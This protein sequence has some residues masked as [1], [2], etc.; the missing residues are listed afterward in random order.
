MCREEGVHQRSC[1]EDNPRREGGSSRGNEGE[2]EEPG[3][4]GNLQE[5]PLYG[6]AGSGRHE[7]EPEE[8]DDEPTWGREGAG[9]VFTD[10]FSQQHKEDSEAGA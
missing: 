6:G 1:A 2:V 5:T 8:D 3:G 9:R 4:Q 10:V 7:V